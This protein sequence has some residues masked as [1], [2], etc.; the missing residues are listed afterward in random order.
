V[1]VRSQS[2]V[3]LAA[4]Q[5]AATGE[6]G[7]LLVLAQDIKDKGVAN[8]TQQTS[9]R[10]SQSSG[11][12]IG[13]NSALITSAVAL[14][15]TL[16]QYEGA[17]GNKLKTALAVQGFDQ[18]SSLNQAASAG[19]LVDGIANGGVSISFGQS[20]SQSTQTSTTSTALTS[21]LEANTVQL[22]AQNNIS[23]TGAEITANTA[24]LTAIDGQV[25]LVAAQ[26]TQTTQSESSSQG[27][28]IGLG[29]SKKGVQLT[30]SANQAEGTQ[31]SQ[32]TQNKETVI[33]AQ[34]L[35]LNSGTDTVL[36][37]AVLQ[38]DRI[39]GTIGGD[40]IISSQQ[41]TSTYTSDSKSAGFSVGI[42]LPGG[43]ASLSKQL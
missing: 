13:S 2:T 11:I 16:T 23:L 41:D 20:S 38:A 4:T 32:S 7:T 17:R 18:L 24:S 10:Q 8:T 14:D 15:N 3:T 28:S 19:D 43:T 21:S 25:S 1:V 9:T 35:T 39:T 27:S 26:N 36:T 37:G 42:P 30:I 34:N 31:N 6:D 12:S 40:L 29:I 22:E 5:A 33:K